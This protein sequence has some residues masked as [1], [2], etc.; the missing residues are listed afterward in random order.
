MLANAIGWRCLFAPAHRLSIRA[1]LRA[2]WIGESINGLLP[3]LQVGGNVAKARFVAARGVVAALAGAT[4]VVDVMLMVST[5]VVFTLIGTGLL[6]TIV[7]G[8]RVVVGALVGA[9]IMA[10]LVGGFYAA[11]R[12]GLF[13]GLAR[14]LGRVLGQ[15]TGDVLTTNAAAL[16]E[17]IHGLYRAPRAIAL[18]AAWHL[19]SWIAGAGEVWLA[20]H[21]LG[22]PA[23]IQQAVLLESLGQALRTSAFLVPGALGVQEGGYLVL[24]TALGM[25]PDT[26]LAL[27]LAKRVREVLLGIPGLLVWQ[28]EGATSLVRAGRRGA[29]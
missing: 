19:M 3:V 22:Y 7:G 29:V 13:G 28:A 25:P 4:V 14:R 20:L 10:T 27:S 8:Q 16:D 24:G 11:Q 1:M 12:R 2:R 5:Q 15:E 26:A 18:G 9:G 6:V 21:F 17:A 23:S